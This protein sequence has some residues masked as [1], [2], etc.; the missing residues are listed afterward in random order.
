LLLNQRKKANT[1]TG[2]ANATVEMSLLFT[3]ETLGA[4]GRQEAAV[5]IKA[6]RLMVIE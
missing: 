3:E 4:P 1:F 5:A 6:G 2:F